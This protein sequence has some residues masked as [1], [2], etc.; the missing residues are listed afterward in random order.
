MEAKSKT[1]DQKII[2]RVFKLNE[3]QIHILN[4]PA[5]FN[6]ALCSILMNAKNRVYF[7]S[8]YADGEN[9]VTK[10]L[11]S[12]AERFEKYAWKP[13]IKFILD[14]NRTTNNKKRF[15][16]FK[17]QDKFPEIVSISLCKV[18]INNQGKIRDRVINQLIDILS[19]YKN[20]SVFKELLGVYHIKLYLVDDNLIITGANLNLD[21]LTS[22]QDRYI[23][24]LNSREICDYF[25]HALDII[26]NYSYKLQ[27][28]QIRQPEKLE[29]NNLKKEL[30]ELN[31]SSCIQNEL[32]S[33]MKIKLNHSNC[34]DE[35]IIA[36][37]FQCAPI[38]I[39]SEKHLITMMSTLC[40]EIDTDLLIVTPYLNFPKYFLPLFKIVKNLSFISG[41]P[42][43]KSREMPKE[44]KNSLLNKIR[45]LLLPE[46]YDS[47]NISLQKQIN[48]SKEHKLSYY[49]YKRRK[50]SLHF[51]GIYF[52]RNEP[53]K[54]PTD[55]KQ[56][57][58][59]SI[60]ATILGSSNFN[61]RSA[62]K[63]LECSF[64]LIPGKSKR[65]EDSFKDELRNITDY[66]IE[67]HA[68]RFKL[69]RFIIANFV[70]MLQSYL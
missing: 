36:S 42:I 54:K 5:S 31:G 53:D 21:Y 55:I 12:V 57:F 68:P 33:N 1:V 4:S 66:S 47:I 7:S 29:F 49:E 20:M 59:S 69:R 51:K 18:P 64:V 9:E 11:Y 25:E 14:Y 67:R 56:K 2:G 43:W 61:H 50:W 6:N 65:L 38:N 17:I 16:Y 3:D 27:K 23:M 8:L 10:T 62:S 15:S 19:K 41:V 63:D 70:K 52:F 39:E 60:F 30:L 34:P 40:Q 26:G 58:H 37:Y 22:K 24:I 46:L 28:G 32:A 48:S 35:C 44:S 13:K 45:S